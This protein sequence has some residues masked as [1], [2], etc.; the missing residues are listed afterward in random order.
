M[1]GAQ[2]NLAQTDGSTPLQLAATYGHYD[3][4]DLLVHLGADHSVCDE[5][6]LAHESSLLATRKE[7]AASNK[8][9]SASTK[10]DVEL[11]SAQEPSAAIDSAAPAMSENNAASK[12]EESVSPKQ[13]SKSATD[14][15]DNANT[16]S[17][18]EANGTAQQEDSAAPDTHAK[19]TDYSE[20]PAVVS[21]EA[22][23]APSNDAIE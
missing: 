7:N 10:D 13:E 1:A 20:E 22:Y 5:F 8:N 23:A 18:G 12:G 2:L 6:G 16:L 21:N 15:A 4:C 19:T 14:A 9:S 17:V 3:L 11:E